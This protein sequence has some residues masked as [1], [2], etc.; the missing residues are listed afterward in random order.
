MSSSQSPKSPKGPESP[1]SPASHGGKAA[2]PE[3]SPAPPAIVALSAEEIREAGILPGAHWTEQPIEQVDDDGASTIGSIAS[4]TASLTSTIFEYR[5]VHGRTYHG[6]IG[7]AES[8][9]PN[10]Q[11]HVDSLDIFHHTFMLSLGDK[12]FLSPLE[13]NKIHKVLDVGTGTGLWAIDFADE[14]PNAEVIGTDVSPIQPSWVPPNV[15][16]ELDDCNREWTWNEDSFDFVHL[17]MLLGVV[18][19][20]SDIFRNAFRCAR[21]GGYVESM[22]SSAFFRSD[23]GS[24]KKG[25]ALEQW[26]SIFWEGGKKL[27]RTFRVLEDDLQKKA[28]E[29]A[30][31]VDIA[32]KD[33]KI[34]LGAWPED[35][36]LAEIGLWW[37]MSLESDLEGYLNYLCN[38][39]LGWTTEET[40]AYCAHVRKEWNDPNIHSYV[41]L[42]VVYG[43]KP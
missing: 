31:F 35:K 18:S 24:V 7:N 19:N 42:R 26:H 16:F 36:K 43:R 8:W 34:P 20:W 28:M 37:K 3:P 40:A 27:G 15:K 30:G 13:K 25:S 17:R 5:T 9:E 29:E 14:F 39:L 6:E 23:D 2:S 11:R 21:S 32:V 10:D 33:I 38:A 4:T 41:W 12:L 22:V 1:R